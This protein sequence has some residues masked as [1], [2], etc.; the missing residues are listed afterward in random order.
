MR[1][2]SEAARAPR[3]E[4]TMKRVLGIVAFALL[5]SACATNSAI[6]EQVSPLSDRVTKMESQLADMNKRLDAQSA[7]LQT[8]QK[9]LSDMN[10]AAQKAQQA[11]SDAQAAATRAETAADK[12]SKAFELSQRKGAR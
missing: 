7:D 12:A 1:R 3:R 8:A 6:K 11:A 9:N 10:A 5:A 4:E 2:L